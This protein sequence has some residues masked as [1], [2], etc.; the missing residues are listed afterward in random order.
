MGRGNGM[1]VILAEGPVPGGKHAG[2][3]YTVLSG[4]HIAPN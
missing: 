3:V 1:T 4:M 2:I